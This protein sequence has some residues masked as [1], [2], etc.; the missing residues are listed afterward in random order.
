MGRRGR[1]GSSSSVTR[2]PTARVRGT[3]M[4]RW[5][6]GSCANCNARGTTSTFACSRCPA[7]PPG[8][9]RPGT[10]GGLGRDGP[11]P[12]RHWGER[13]H[14]AGAT[15][16]GRGRTGCGDNSATGRWCAGRRRSRPGPVGLPGDTAGLPSSRPSGVPAASA[17]PGCCDGDGWRRGGTGVGRS[18]ASVRRRSGAVLPGPLPPVL[19]RICPDRGRPGSVRP[20]GRARQGKQTTYLT[21]QGGPESVA[22]R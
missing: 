19:G 6:P 17:E 4:R 10:T 8:I 18:R 14:P 16:T 3:S 12:D 5:G 22:V 13:S 21:L 1:S 11:R 2:S 20:G 7:P 9:W 15:R